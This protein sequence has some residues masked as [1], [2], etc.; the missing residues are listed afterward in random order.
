MTKSTHEPIKPVKK[1]PKLTKA[2]TE[3]PVQKEVIK[4]LK[5]QGCWVMK[6]TPTPGVPTGTADV[7]FCKEG[8]YGWIECKANKNSKRRPGQ[9]QFI[10]KMDD[11]SYAKFVHKDNLAEIKKELGEML[12]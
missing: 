8:L 7:F 2:D 6:I 11:W 1:C 12:K 10:K 5:E 4:F 9:P 3:A